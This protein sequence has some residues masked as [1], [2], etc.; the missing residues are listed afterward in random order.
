MP[1]FKNSVV[2]LYY[3]NSCNGDTFIFNETTQS[4]EYTIKKRIT[5]EKGK[6]LL[7]DG[8]NYHSSSPASNSN[9]R[10]V[11]SFNYYEFNRKI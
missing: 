1:A 5:P 9:I 8:N 6:L 7:F 3:V 2:A 10:L 11:I 4:K